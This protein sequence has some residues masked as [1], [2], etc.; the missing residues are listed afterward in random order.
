MSADPPLSYTTTWEAWE[1]SLAVHNAQPN[2]TVQSGARDQKHWT[3][4]QIILRKTI[5]EE[6]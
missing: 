2:P 5:E 4:P 1:A 3:D 6:M